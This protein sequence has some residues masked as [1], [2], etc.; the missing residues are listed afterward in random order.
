MSEHAF[1]G[2]SLPKIDA[3]EKVTGEAQYCVDVRL[4]GML[5]G[6]IKRSPLPCAKIS[7][8]DTTKAERVRGVAAVITGADT[9]KIPYGVYVPDEVP[10]ATDMVRFVGD[11]V[12]AVAAFDEDVAAEALELIQVDYEELPR[13]L[14]RSKPCCLML[15]SYIPSWGI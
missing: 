13:F 14:I 10:L 5:Y 9:P 8:I 11:E 6:K 2:K 4:P 3:R 15:P 7:H 1:I 12:A